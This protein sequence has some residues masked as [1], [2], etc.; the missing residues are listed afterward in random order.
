MALPVK[1]VLPFGAPATGRRG[2]F[3]S[4]FGTPGAGTG[5]P[6]V[7]LPAPGAAGET[8]HRRAQ[9]SRELLRPERSLRAWRFLYQSDRRR[10]CPTATMPATNPRPMTARA[11][12]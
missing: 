7:A 2:L 10:R 3:G 1:P 4:P 8:S 5:V 11:S 6:R 12:T 9:A